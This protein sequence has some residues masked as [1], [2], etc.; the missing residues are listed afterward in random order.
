MKNYFTA[1]DLPYSV[2]IMLCLATYLMGHQAATP[3][4]NVA[5]VE[6]GAVILEAT[7]DR[8]NL[9]EAQIKAQVSGPI[10]AV[11]RRYQQS[12]YVVIDTSRNDQGDI[13]VA[14]MP[15]NTIDITNELRVAVHLPLQKPAPA[16]APAT[17][18]NAAIASNHE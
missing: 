7:L 3:A 2:A 12:G 11:L 16:A 5:I 10:K 13:T 1:G 4:R 18:S 9:S 14:A 15:S 8:P 17:A 6:K